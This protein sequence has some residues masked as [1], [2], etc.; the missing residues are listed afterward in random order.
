MSA[1]ADAAVLEAVV[2]VRHGAGFALTAALDAAAGETVAVMGPSGAGKSTLLA[3]L[4]GLVP[5]HGGHVRLGGTVLSAPGRTVEPARRDT[6][7]LGQDPRLFPHLSVLENVAFPLRARGVRA[8]AARERARTLLDRVG[9]VDAAPRRPADLSGGQ[10]QRVALA[11]ALAASPRLLLLDEPLTSLDPGTAGEIR[12][13][14]A[15]LLRPV[16]CVVVTHDAVDAV[17]LAD[18]LVVVEAGAVTQTGPVREVFAAPATDFVAGVAGL[19][20]VPGEVRGGVW[21]AGPL[22]LPAPHTP[23]GPAVLVCPPA[24]VTLAA[25]GAAASVHR[26]EQTLGGVLLHLDVPGL[27]C[28]LPFDVWAQHPYAPGDRVAVAVDPTAARFLPA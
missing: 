23:D 15:E 24:R 22:V 1:A 9:L 17:A 26:V 5:L 16:T 8:A 2:E 14:L 7:L 19:G 20:R 27:A 4:A 21:S 10:Q 11:R 3:A 13:L 28:E 18:R 12:M 25:A 6:V